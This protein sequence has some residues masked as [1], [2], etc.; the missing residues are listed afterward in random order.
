MTSFSNFTKIEYNL[1]KCLR[2]SLHQS[3]TGAAGA[4]P[5]L[6]AKEW[7][8]LIDA[9]DRHEVLSLFSNMPQAQAEKIPKE[10]R[11]MIQ[12]RTAKV[13]HTGIMLQA[14]N[15]K[16]TLLLESEGITAVTL[17]G[18]T[19]SRFYPVPEFRKTSD[20]DLFVAERRRSAT[21][22]VPI[23]GKK[24]LQLPAYGGMIAQ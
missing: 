1:L 11:H 17:K 18:C 2:L 24:C 9:A 14:L 6:S 3:G 22:Y 16:L 12:S 23:C 5:T 8:Q 10:Q 13:V 21:K 7:H 15:A 20:I 4:L 19:V